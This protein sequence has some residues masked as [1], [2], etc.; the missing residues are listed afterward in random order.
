M[1]CAARCRVALRVLV[2]GLFRSRWR[3][4]ATLAAAFF[5]GLL[6][7]F[8][9]ISLADGTRDALVEPLAATLTGDVRVTQGSTDLAAGTRWVDHRATTA[10]LDRIPGADASARFESSYISV[11]GDAFENWSA[12]L[13]IGVEPG[14]PAETEALAPYMVWG[15]PVTSLDVFHPE[16]NRAYAP[17][18]LGGPAF[19]RL[20][21]T[22]NADGSP[23][24][25]Q[26]LTLTSGRTLNEGG[27]PIPVTVDCVV[28][29]VFATGLEPL[30]KFTAYVPIQ[31]ARVLAGHL[32]ND[33]TANAIVV[34]GAGEEPVRA[35]L[36]D[37]PGTQ[38]ESANAFAFGYM[39]SMLVI[40]YAA[41]GATLAIFLAALLTWLSHETG[42]LV[43]VDQG[44]ISSLRAVGVP[45]RAIQGSYA[46]L[47]GAAVVVGATAAVLV[48]VVL[49]AFAPPLRI[50]LEG[51]D[52]A[53]SLGV[54]P[55]ALAVAAVLSVG[56]VGL[57]T[58]LAARRIQALNILDG[59]RGL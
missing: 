15:T 43:R 2:R 30:D 11:R 59:L 48:A 8:L 47:L 25:N 26:T 7:F 14:A 22:A 51:V 35:A 10:A 1:A 44:V 24:F 17:L 58:W 34:R 16:T 13:L 36:E 55:L 4:Y 32:E 40:I 53:V 5:V 20:N 29:G 31:T 27:V 21:L 33:P 23:L 39:G 6:A 3:R 52:A 41:G 57:S 49:G 28:V 46:V 54:H 45:D 9:V 12:G 38:T 50:S 56:A 18:V 37:T 42:V 19:E